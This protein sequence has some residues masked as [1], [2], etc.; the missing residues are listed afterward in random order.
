[1]C[2]RNYPEKVHVNSNGIL[3]HSSSWESYCL[4]RKYDQYQGTDLAV[5]AINPD[6][7]IVSLQ[8]APLPDSV[9]SIPKI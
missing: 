4:Y 9:G 3:I 7:N 2:S 5:K 8:L 1:M 6:L